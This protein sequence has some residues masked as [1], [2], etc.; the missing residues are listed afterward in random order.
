MS[1]IV[2]IVGTVSNPRMRGGRG[3]KVRIFNVTSSTSGRVFNCSADF[4]CNVQERDNIDGL[5][6]MLHDGS[7]KLTQ[8]PI[9]HIPGDD[10][11]ILETFVKSTYTA[12]RVTP[13][14]AKSLLKVMKSMGEVGEE[15]TDTIN[16]LIHSWTSGAPKPDFLE[17]LGI[18]SKAL[19]K[20]INHWVKSRIVRPLHLLGLTNTEINR[21][22]DIGLNPMELY[23]RVKRNPL[24]VLTIP[25]NK[26]RQIIQ[27]LRLTLT[28]DQIHCSMIVRKIH[29]VM[30]NRGWNCAPLKLMMKWF[31]DLIKYS[32]M[33]CSDK[34]Y[35]VV[36]DMNSVYLRKVHECEEFIAKW[37]KDAMLESEFDISDLS[38]Y[39]LYSQ[40]IGTSDATVEA[41]EDND[42]LSNEQRQAV[43]SSLKNKLSI[44]TGGPGTGKTSV[45]KE[46]VTLQRERNREVRVTSFMGKAVAR[47]R[48][49]VGDEDAATMDYLLVPRSGAP[50]ELDH[51]IIDEC[52]MV[53]LP[54]LTKFIQRF[55]PKQVTLVGDIDQ[56]E[57]IGYGCVFSQLL[58]T[59][60][61]RVH[62]TKIFRT[63]ASGIVQNLENVRLAPDNS[64]LS[65]VTGE[66]FNIIQGDINLV[67]SIYQKMRQH[68][69]EPKMITTLTM[70]KRD[71]DQLNKIIQQVFDDYQDSIVFDGITYRVGDRI[72]AVKNR[73]DIKVMNGEEGTIVQ[74]STDF[75]DVQFGQ[76]V[77]R[78]ELTSESPDVPSGNDESMAGEEGSSMGEL[79]IHLLKHSYSMTVHKSQGSEWNIIIVYLP[80][81]TANESFITKKLIYTALSRAKNQVWCIHSG[82]INHF[83]TKPSRFKYDNTAK[84]IGIVRTSK[85]SQQDTQDYNGDDFD[86]EALELEFM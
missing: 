1:Q 61:P 44:I 83:L 17:M 79:T 27:Q 23:S 60:V 3:S 59:A 41:V 52:S 74:V 58:Q 80:D 26:C 73:H 62:L 50:K 64:S 71:V 39:P 19:D 42:D 75:I 15:A 82:P 32:E 5:A 29:E 57:P 65:L 53:Q 18:P 16:R 54:L 7:L 8:P 12:P 40:L 49:V 81:S 66:G 76:N 78:F 45:I 67:T 85:P 13:D 11:S 77:H 24:P 14:M 2:Q 35:D 9:V 72:M 55:N 68:G 25:I 34:D 63:G 46:I 31:P 38:E 10:Q 37:T 4:F 56:L 84:R 43:I 69:A 6:E 20:L 33:L 47:L 30:N 86:V 36:F 51:V 48:E 21:S 28:D 22:K 70:Y